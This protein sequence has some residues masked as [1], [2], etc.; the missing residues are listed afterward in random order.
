MDDRTPTVKVKDFAELDG[1]IGMRHMRTL[2]CCIPTLWMLWKPFVK[3]ILL[4]VK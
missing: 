2:V 1:S 4:M 3:M